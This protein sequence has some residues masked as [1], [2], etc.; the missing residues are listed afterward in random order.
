MNNNPPTISLHLRSAD[1]SQDSK[2][3]KPYL[4]QHDSTF[5]HHIEISNEATRVQLNLKS[6]MSED[7]ALSIH[8]LKIQ[9]AKDEA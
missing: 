8:A 3:I 6:E 2:L 4:A 9:P 7:Q 1:Q 5:P